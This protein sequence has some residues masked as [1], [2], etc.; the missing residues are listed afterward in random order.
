M[1]SIFLGF[2]IVISE[3]CSLRD[4][5]PTIQA[6]FQLIRNIQ[7]LLDVQRLQFQLT[8]PPTTAITQLNQNAL[9][10]LGNDII[11]KEKVEVNI[12]RNPHTLFLTATNRAANLVNMMAIDI[13]FSQQLPLANILGANKN[14]MDVYKH[15]LVVVTENS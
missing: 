11:T 5:D 6:C 13:L 7:R 4:S 14:A 10:S 1:N 12:R 8:V 2:E 15:M 3:I 9:A